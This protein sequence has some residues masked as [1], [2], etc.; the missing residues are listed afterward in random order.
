MKKRYWL[1]PLLILA[2]PA[3]LIVLFSRF[4]NSVYPEPPKPAVKYAEFPL[5]AVYIMNGQRHELR[6][7]IIGEYDGT[8]WNEGNG[9]FRKW[10]LTLKSSGADR[11]TLVK[12]K[13]GDVEIEIFFSLGHAEYLMGDPDKDRNYKQNY[14]S[15][16]LISK[17][18]GRM[19]STSLFTS[20]EWSEKYNIRI[21]E[22]ETGP[23]IQNHFEA[24][25]G[26]LFEILLSRTMF[27]GGWS[28]Y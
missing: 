7:T 20:G 26:D 25:N 2:V 11:L 4:V 17:K 28:S 18:E 23:P 10:K 27:N 6:D 22:W 14:P 21:L 9:K 5:H 12:T 15:S 19:N 3:L 13:E 24:E 16:P 8:G 1:I